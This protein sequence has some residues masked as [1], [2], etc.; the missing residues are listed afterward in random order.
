MAVG[1]SFGQLLWT[2]ASNGAEIANALRRDPSCAGT[3]CKGSRNYHG[4]SG[5]QHDRFLQ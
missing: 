4:V 5:R 3:P 2:S 1:T